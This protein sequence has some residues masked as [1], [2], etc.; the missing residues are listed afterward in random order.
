MPSVSEPFGLVPL[1]AIQSG[2]P[3]IL[4]NQSGVAEI[5]PHTIKVDFWDTDAMADAI[6]GALKHKSLFNTVKNESRNDIRRITWEQAAKKLNHIY[7][8]LLQA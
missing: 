7:H 2:V 5:I 8:E 6:C 3:V 1:E 4:S